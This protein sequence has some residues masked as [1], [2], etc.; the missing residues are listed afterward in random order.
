MKRHNFIVFIACI[1][2]VSFVD[3]QDTAIPD[4]NFEN[5]LETHAA[6]GTVVAIG[7]ASS[8]G[9]G[10]ANNGSVPTNRI[11]NVTILD[12]SN[13]DISDLTGTEDFTALETLICSDNALSTLNVSNNTNLI[14][15]LCGSNFL[16]ELM[17]NNNSSLETLNCSDNQIQSLDILNNTAL[18]SLTASGNQLSAIDLS[19][20]PEL[21]LLGVSNNRIAGELVVSNNPDLERL[22]CASNQILT[23]NLASNP[24]LKNLDVSNNQLTSLDLSTINSVVCPDPQTDP[25]TVCQDMA[26]IDVSRNQLSSLVVNNGYNEL[27]SI[28]NAS[29]NPGLFC[30][31]ID[32]GYTPSGWIKDDWTYFS[33]NTCEDIYTY[34][35]D[36]NFEQALI[37]DGHDDIL[38]NL[39]LTENIDVLKSL[40]VSNESIS[41]LVGIEDFSA[42][43]I[44]DCSTNSIENLDVS[45]NT[46]LIQIDVTN[47]NLI[48]LDL[49]TNTAVTTIYCASNMIEHLDLSTNLALTT[50]NCSNNNLTNLDVSTIS[51]LNNFDCS[52]NQMESLNL[53]SNNALV[54][55]LCNDNNLFALNINNGNNTSITTFNA[56]NNNNL[57]CIQVDDEAFPDTAGWQKDMGAS[58]NVA[59]GTY[60]PDDNFEQELIDIGIDSDGIL[61]NFVATTD[62]NSVLALDISNLAIADLTGIQDFEDLIDLNISYNILTNIDLSNNTDLE[63]LD[64]S[65]NE[66]TDLDL[67]LNAALTS[68]LCNDNS[69]LTINIENGNNGALTTFNATNNP[70]LYCINVDDAIVGSIPGSWQKDDFAAYNG[71]CDT[72]RVTAIPDGFFEQ[73]LI[74]FGF[75]DVL[76]GEVKTANIEHIQNLDVSDKSISDL[77]G[78]QDFKSLVE[79]DCSGNFLNT[80]DVSDMLFLER[81][82]CSSNYLLTNDINDEAGLFNTTGTISLKA[83]YC[84]GNNL[85]NLDI[86]Q[87][88]NLEILD[89][90]DNNISDLNVNNNALLRVLYASNNNMTILDLSSNTALEDVNCDSNQISDLTTLETIN[91]T[92]INLSC[93]NNDI[94]NLSVNNYQALEALNVS[95]NELTQLNV[96]DNAELVFLSITNNQISEITFL[97]NGNLV[98]VLASQNS[99]Q[100]L[101]LSANTLLEFLNCDFNELTALDLVSN[102]SLE[103]LSC[104]NNQLTELDLLNNGNL[105]AVDFSSNM[106]SS[107]ILP[108]NLEFLKRLDASNNQ[109]ENDMDLTV[110]AISACV[111]QPNQ[112]EFCPEIISINVSNNLLSFVN[113]QNGINT[114]IASF[115]ASGNPNLECIQVDDA[116]NVNASWI[117]DEA[118]T[119]S[120]DCNFG[121]TYVPDDNFEQ[122]LID[123]G[124]DSG[125]LNDY[126]LT[127][128]IVD[129]A[130]LEVNGNAII[131]LTGI[132]DFAALQTLYC[133]NNAIVELDLSSN[134][135]LLEV[136]CS[137]NLLTDLDLTN[138]IALLTL[139]CSFNTI[140]TLDLTANTNLSDLNISNNTLTSFLPSDLLSLQVFNCN[141]NS[142]VTLDFQQNQNLTSI[143]CESNLL[144]T[145]NIKNGQNAV[146]TNLNAINN[147]NLL[148]I[149]TDNG[150]VPTGAT[151]NIDATAQFAVNCFFG[152]TYVPDDNFEQALIDIGYDSGPLNDYVF[153]E[154]IEEITFLNVS[155]REISDVTGLEAFVAL[156]TLNVEDNTISNVDLGNNLSLVN[157]DVSDNLL[158]ILEISLLTNLTKLDVSNNSLSQINF[159][160]NLSLDDINVS[161]NSI[162]NLNV[163]GLVNLEEL[164]C[165]G[166]QLSSLN[167]TQNPNLTLLFCQS[168]LLF[169]DQLNI[170]NGNNENL[171]LFNAINNPSLGCILVDNPI[172][173]IE[174]VDG[175]YDNWIK[176]DSASYQSICEDADNDGVPNT[177][178][179]CPNTDFGAAVDLFGCAIPDLQNDNFTVLITGETCLNSNNGKI[180]ITA[181]EIYNYT[182]TL[183]GEDILDGTGEVFY[184]EYNFTNDV[185][186]FNLLADTYELCITIEEWP[187][188]QSCYTIVITEP[189]PLSVFASRPASG[190]DIT[191]DMS[192]STIYYIQF[193]DDSFTTHNS[194]FSLQLQQGINQLKV[195]TD[196]DCQG[197]F[198]EQIIKADEPLLFPNPFKNE[199]NIYDGNAGDEVTVKMYST[200]GQL[201]LTKTFINQGVYNA[202]DTEHLATGIYLMSIQTKSETSTF[203]IVKK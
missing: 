46:E 147:P 184:Q 55:V 77:T 60:I 130:S 78:I 123:L 188:Y 48:V 113:I 92:L 65:N 170:Q 45:S 87:N 133:S 43:E 97:N 61:N 138:N 53:V 141:N 10:F 59:C 75:D 83:L 193:N 68:L 122:A 166:N 25:I 112:T 160:T 69:L 145:L 143:S 50:L 146:L 64:C 172:A 7:D 203:K 100:T 67:T 105:I 101:D 136:D 181:Q 66:I 161:N 3:A 148:C 182:A 189:N 11:E 90:A 28:F 155:G 91:T 82:N 88:T 151:W 186:I 111:F 201:V 40:D 110:M 107:V 180:T 81:L 121:E 98:E 125:P 36:D 23:L 52:F 149:E 109:I 70:N 158:D 137:D 200:F 73:S 63:I 167:V 51:L 163:S 80:L 29:D 159:D 173:V 104:S 99:L 38:D 74:D 34:V 142:I 103:S 117:K 54:S 9:D 57:F 187:D 152:E 176:D 164:N 124:Y 21:S 120:E 198:E 144:E 192:G 126:V 177:D 156:T 190:S 22:F 157:L 84:A 4:A 178:D 127:A 118:T 47:N 191:L 89:C 49:S 16:T 58:Y 86:S 33:E 183:I 135:N 76:D 199:L 162:I 20:N 179:L 174:N 19:S 165:A 17:L 132:E 119:Y 2:T 134:S 169:A 197:V 139:N 185:D 128:N 168:N 32:N 115:N 154:N 95:S 171:G 102:P 85:N 195:S 131:D 5:Y 96:D 37:N 30:I 114:E 106:I 27:F 71:D 12:V 35:P 24:I 140:S 175:I 15:L 26:T 39:V 6:D 62:I 79:F 14:T 108:N 129:L 31:Q 18:K 72:N 42:L 56:T 202:I 94:I 150:T 1:L 153:T 196:L 116:D 93:A 8:M 41:S 194:T 44:L 13:L